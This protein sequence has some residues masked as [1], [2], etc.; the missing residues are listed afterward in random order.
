MVAGNVLNVR[1]IYHIM[2]EGKY[3]SMIS[4]FFGNYNNLVIY[5]HHF[6]VIKALNMILQVQ[7]LYHRC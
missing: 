4:F 1:E 6:G 7:Y 3:S 5:L 2:I